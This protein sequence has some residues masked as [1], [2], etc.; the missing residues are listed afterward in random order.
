MRW[1]GK[2]FERISDGDQNRQSYG[3]LFRK[4]TLLTVVCSVGPLLLVGWG[5]NAYHTYFTKDRV[6]RQFQG[7]V[8]NHRR[9]VEQFLKEQ[10]S[11]LR[12][13]TYTHS[14]DFLLVP[15][16]LRVVYE[17]MNREYQSITDLG[18]IDH[19][20]RH[21]AYVGPYDLLDRNYA[22]AEWFKEV[23]HKG[24]YISDMFTGFREEPHFI[25]AI[26]RSEGK[27]QWIL[28]A[29]VNTDVFRTLVE[30]VRI[31]ETGEVYLVNSRG[32]Y[33]TSP[34]FSGEI[35]E[36]SPIEIEDLK[37][38]VKVG[39]VNGVSSKG[40][41]SKQ[42]IGKSW[43]DEPRWLLV[44]KQDYSEAFSEIHH[45][46][47]INLIFL[48]I[49]AI[50]ILVVSLFITRYM[51]KI[52][53]N[54]DEHAGQLNLQLLQASKLASIGE[55][56]AGVAHEINNPVAIISTERQLL[57]DQFK[58]TKVEDEIFRTQFI[59]S[60]DQI[61]AQTKRCKRITH[62]LLRFSRRTHSLVEMLDLNNFILEV[63][64]LM[65]REAKT[66]GVKF[67]TEL[68]ALLP[69]I[70]SDI[71]QL[72]Q[73]FLNLITNAID[74]HEGKSYGSIRIATKYDEGGGGVLIT[75]ADTGT[76]ISKENMNRIFDP[77]FT[78]KAV[79]KGTGLGLSICFT[80]IQNL[81][82]NITVRSEKGEGTEFAIFLPLI[83]RIKVSEEGKMDNEFAKYPI[84]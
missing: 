25:I 31:G 66:S 51:V 43:L 75:I 36:K 82:G 55:L 74:A 20:G 57:V 53:R 29:T 49:S 10:S 84:I 48:Y 65:E 9:F 68:D 62:N 13:L 73:V 4:F 23:L 6:M 52:I 5:L 80:I 11:K 77:F 15:G 24:L 58:K 18:V 14:L 61:A 26:S 78:T 38:T 37:E 70:Q 8:E 67:I 50:S 35:M 21:L 76:G 27:G 64:E 19:T 60:M 45:S 16:N 3:H 54:R 69:S 22:E 81:G 59:D 17:N 83:S 71:S 41:S 44:I 2:W 79:G 30:N 32:I 42:I 63:V 12:L 56:A 1:F 40:S 34:R 28:R 39:I 33:Q 46:R 47:R 72:Q 7:Q